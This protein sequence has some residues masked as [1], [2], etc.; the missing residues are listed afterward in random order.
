MLRRPADDGV[1]ALSTASTP[2]S[3]IG[4]EIQALLSRPGDQRDFRRFPVRHESG[5]C[6]IGETA[7]FEAAIACAGLH[8][9]RGAGNFHT[10]VVRNLSM[11]GLYF[12]T[13]L[14]YRQGLRM[15]V[16][17]PLVKQVVN[18]TGVVQR[19]DHPAFTVEGILHGDF[20]CGVDFSYGMM[21]QVSRR[22]LMEYLLAHPD[23]TSWHDLPGIRNRF[24]RPPRPKSA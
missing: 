22:A 9:H 12:V 8:E 3:P 20:G 10:V 24:P 5:I 13:K 14:P 15:E 6:L 16:R 7:P 21:S 23:G 1:M 4:P 11:T 2:P 18:V 19:L 17:I